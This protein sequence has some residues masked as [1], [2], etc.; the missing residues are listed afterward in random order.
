[1]DVSSASRSF[2]LC[3][4][5]PASYT[6]L[7]ANYLSLKPFTQPRQFNGAQ[8]ALLLGDA[9]IMNIDMKYVWYLVV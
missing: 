8:E 9:K 3:A 6:F 5:K 7:C 4:T 1:M 2:I